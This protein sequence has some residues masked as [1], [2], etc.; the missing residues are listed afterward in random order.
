MRAGWR[1]VSRWTWRRTIPTIDPILPELRSSAC[2]SGAD[3]DEDPADQ[4]GGRNRRRSAGV[5]CR[6]LGGQSAQ[7]GA[8]QSGRGRG[9]G[10]PTA[11]FVEVSP[12]PL[13]T[14][15]IGDTLQSRSSADRFIVTSAMK[16]GEGK[17]LFVHTQLATPQCDGPKKPTAAGSPMFLRRRGRTRGTGS[18]RAVVRAADSPMFHPLLGVHVEMPSGRD[19]V[20]Q[21]DI[22]TEDDAVAGRSQGAWA[23]HNDRPRVLPRWRWPP[24]A[25]ALGLPAEAVQVNG[26]EVEQM[27]ALDRQ[28]RVTTQLAQSGRTGFALRFMPVRPAAAGLG[29]R[30]Q[31]ID[32][33]RADG[34]DR[35]AADVQ[36][37]GNRN[38]AARSR[39][40]GPSGV[41]HAPPPCSIRR[42]SSLAAA[43]PAESTGGPTETP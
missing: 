40:P 10:K 28:T 22:G 20:W 17:I 26:L 6:L 39:R 25:E 30:R 9:R 37:P 21:A 14:Y 41:L 3:D 2:G 35:A 38:R 42:C 4:Y 43:I 11:T 29:M 16:Q 18:G 24:A 7:S 31:A 33:A 27:L 36:A 23:G 1:G 34:P 13:L 12:H 15:A 32:V 19:H 5:R 8:V